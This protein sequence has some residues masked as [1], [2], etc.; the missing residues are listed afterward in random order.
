MKL[1]GFYS[2]KKPVI[3]A[4]ILL[5]ASLVIA[6]VLEGMQVLSM[7]K[8]YKNGVPEDSISIGAWEPR[9]VSIYNYEWNSESLTP[10]GGDPQLY[11][12]TSDISG[13]Q[14]AFLEFSEPTETDIAVQLFYA[15]FPGNYS[16]GQSVKTTCPAGTTLFFMPIPVG[17]YANIRV[18][19]DFYGSVALQHVVFAANEP[20]RT[21]IPEPL[22]WLRIILVTVIAFALLCFC[23]WCHSWKRFTGTL[24][25]GFSAL[26]AGGKKNLIYAVL[27]LLII[28][29]TIGLGWLILKVA[30]G[31]GFTGP[32]AVFFGLV[33]MNIAAAVTFRKT[34]KEQPEYLFL[35]VC[36]SIGLLFCLYIPHTGLNSWDEEYHYLRA[37]ETSYVDELRMTAQDNL[38]LFLNGADSF[39]L[40]NGLKMMHDSQ[41]SLYRAGAISVYSPSFVS[42]KS[43]SE[44][45]NGIGLFLGRVLGLR[46]Y[47]MLILGRFT[48]MLAYALV[49]FFAMRKLKSGKMIVAVCMLI[50]TSLFLSGAYNYD[51]YL[52]GFSILGLSYYFSQW[53]NRDE[54][55]STRDM[56]IMIGSLVFAC[57][58][59]AV[60]VPL[61]WIV[62]FLPKS[63]FVN[64]KQQWSYYGFVLLG[65]LIVVM[66]YLL[67]NLLNGGNGMSTDVRGG[68]V[69]AGAQLALIISDPLRYASVL[70]RYLRDQYLNFANAQW[71]LT[72]MA[73]HGLMPHQHLYL[74]LLFTV[75]FTDKNEYDRPFVGRWFA[76]IGPLVLTA[77][78]LIL[79]VT[80]MYLAFTPVGSDTVNGAQYRYMI[81]LIYPLLA[82]IGSGLVDNKMNRA[83]YNAVILSAAAFV[84][85]ASVLITFVIRYY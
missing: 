28:G 76:H 8:L 58:V 22:N 34:L 66:S 62:L 4:L 2:G 50:P 6:C 49:G 64:R 15:D 38:P 46:Y 52:T 9:M 47:Q 51:T 85:Y 31:K 32:L 59:K 24:E 21:V 74:L 33:G 20:I 10:V 25:S 14:S 65:S 55:A 1:K 16:E 68:D 73:Y 36:I 35:L 60:Y 71:T 19:M 79:V 40:N 57:V 27:F 11:F 78:T 67:P 82:H 17:N 39:D 75:A 77:G 84:G 29:A 56:F 37:L 18:D 69:D 13:L 63:K 80:S 54:K 81:P 70:W 83:W 44:V 41:D 5:A 12:E 61:L 7:P 23:S 43:V 48:G 45:F 30:I 3:R 42:P 53:Q 72:N 26:K